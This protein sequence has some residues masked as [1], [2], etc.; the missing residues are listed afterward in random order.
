LHQRTASMEC[1]FRSV[2]ALLR[3]STYSN[4]LTEPDTIREMREEFVNG[5]QY[6][7]ELFR[8]RHWRCE[9]RDRRGRRCKNYHPGH[10]FEHQFDP[11]SGD[12]DY[13]FGN[14]E[15]T[16]PGHQCSWQPDRFK[17]ELERQLHRLKSAEQARVTLTSVARRI[18]LLRVH[19]QR[20]C[21]ACLSHSPTNM[22][23][24]QGVKHGICQTCLQQFSSRGQHESVLTID[25]CPLGCAF[26]TGTWSI[27][28]KP[29]AAGPRILALDG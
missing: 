22:L 15:S 29:R 3:T 8:Y 10:R 28:V 1:K 21:L 16:R 25:R 12:A 4:T 27:R 5:A 2:T 24:C 17:D 6:G 14:K 18:G 19:S 13:E 9:A 26:D 23:P 7:L 20:T 11:A